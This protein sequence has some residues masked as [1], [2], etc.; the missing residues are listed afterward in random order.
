MH[1]LNS[2]PKYPVLLILL[3]FVL[4]TPAFS[5]PHDEKDST[6]TWEFSL[7]WIRYLSFSQKKTDLPMK[8]GYPFLYSQMPSAGIGYRLLRKKTIHQANLHV[9]IP[10]HLGSENGNGDNLITRKKKSS[11]FRSGIH[12]RV[13]FQLFQ[14]K[15]LYAS[16]AFLSGLLYEYRNIQY[17]SDAKEITRDINLYIG[18]EFTFQYDIHK[19][20][21]IEGTFDARFYIP[22]ANFGRIQSFNSQGQ[23]IFSSCYRAFYY[24]AI[25]A[26]GLEYNIPGKRIAGIGIK[27]NDMVGFA[28]RKPLFYVEDI[29]HFKLDKLLHV[30]IQYKF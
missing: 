19:D 7:A 14:W 17:K 26:L 1:M 22:Y 15:S 28:N 9:T 3:T 8:A 13:S 23:K 29:V 21:I 30:Y 20:W 2:L 12:Y 16:H 10:T 5:Q 27:K 24:Q 11:Y 18:P 6:T 25:F 4:I